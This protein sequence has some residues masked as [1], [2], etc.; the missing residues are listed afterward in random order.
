MHSTLQVR[1]TGGLPLSIYYSTAALVT[2]SVVM[3]ICKSQGHGGEI[4]EP[5]LSAYSDFLGIVGVSSLLQVQAVGRCSNS[6]TSMD[7]PKPRQT[8]DLQSL[9]CSV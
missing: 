2:V 7:F 6:S 8:T 9:T 3:S 4:K 1:I 5:V